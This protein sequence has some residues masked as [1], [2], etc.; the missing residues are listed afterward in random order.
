M[1]LVFLEQGGILPERKG[2]NVHESLRGDPWKCVPLFP[3]REPAH[4]LTRA[5]LSAFIAG[6][7]IIVLIQSLNKY[8]RSLATFLPRGVDLR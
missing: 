8:S 7:I 1:T 2:Q 4:P 6:C 5:L 3:E